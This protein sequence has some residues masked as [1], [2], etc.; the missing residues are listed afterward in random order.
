MNARRLIARQGS[1]EGEAWTWQT[2]RRLLCQGFLMCAA[3]AVSRCATV[4][5]DIAYAFPLGGP[6]LYRVTAALYRGV[7]ILLR[8]AIDILPAP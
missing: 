2:G 1:R 8:R 3:A 5:L 4:M 6:R 7:G